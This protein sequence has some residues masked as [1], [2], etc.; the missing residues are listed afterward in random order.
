MSSFVNTPDLL[1]MFDQ[2]ADTVTM[3][4]IKQA[5]SEENNGAEFPLPVLKGGR[6]TPI[7]MEKSPAQEA[8]MQDIARRAGIIEGA[9]VE[10]QEI[11]HGL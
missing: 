8:Y 1:K 7:P 4:D 10:R 6:R 9:E 2:V 5:Y 3:E 11:E